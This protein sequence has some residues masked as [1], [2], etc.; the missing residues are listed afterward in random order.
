MNFRARLNYKNQKSDPIDSINNI[1]TLFDLLENISSVTQESETLKK[2]VELTLN[3]ICRFTKW[4]IGH[5]YFVDLIDDVLIAKSSGIWYLD[6]TINSADISDFVAISE[7]TKFSETQGMVGKVLATQNPFTIEDVTV[8][9][10]FS[11]AEEAKRNSVKGCFAFPVVYVGKSR[12]ILEFF[13]RE[14][15]KLDEQTLQILKFVGKQLQFVLIRMDHKT[16]ISELSFELEKTV[17]DMAIKTED[18]VTNLNKTVADLLISFDTVVR[19]INIGYKD[20]HE[21]LEYSE[22]VITSVHEMSDS[23]EDIFLRIKNIN[24]LAD[25]CVVQVKQANSESEQLRN[26]TEQVRNALQYIKNISN[27]T[28]LLALNATIEAARAG[29][30]GKGFAVVAGE[31]KKL[32]SESSASAQTI[33]ETIG[34]MMNVI[35]SIETSLAE[36]DQTVVDIDKSFVT[37][38]KLSEEQSITSKNI[39]MRVK[40]SFEFMTDLSDKLSYSKDFVGTS[41]EKAK[42]IGAETTS[43]VAQVTILREL[44]DRVRAFVISVH[45]KSDSSN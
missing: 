37:I 29:D 44:I 25:K 11:R 8:M 16:L 24:M 45:K 19:N 14:V 9:N 22:S 41:L 26:V 39:I 18:T 5:A 33:E 34:N 23:I 36:A 27:Q 21:T 13:S 10:N 40:N 35:Q 6:D 15:A 20:A 28:N 43:M 1:A 32:A 3:R 17:K 38:T 30:A 4:S 2:A 7:T 42:E 31:V 12:I